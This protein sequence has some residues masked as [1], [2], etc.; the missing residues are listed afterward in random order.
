MAQSK[1]GT[2]LLDR[3]RGHAARVAMPSTDRQLLRRFARRG[4]ESAF[5]N[6]MERHGPLVLNV[7]RRVLRDVHEADDVFQATFLLLARKAGWKGWHES[8]ANW[9]YEA[10]YRLAVKARAAAHCRRLKEGRAAER[11]Q[12]GAMAI[13]ALEELRQALDEELAHLPGRWRAPLV[14]CYLQG[15]TRDEAAQELGWT[16]GMVKSRLERG[17]QL[18]HHRLSRRGLGLSAVLSAVFLAPGAASAVVPRALAE[19]TVEAAAHS[20]KGSPVRVGASA[21]RTSMAVA[22]LGVVLLLLG[23]HFLQPPGGGPTPPPARVVP[24]SPLRSVGEALSE[25]VRAER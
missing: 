16:L 14:L 21:W 12:Q 5:A 17:R 25:H 8:V 18:L 22:V 13:M 7:C 23:V 15:K 3:Q 19:A 6:L 24:A 2:V 1:S 10:A 20:A 4:D 9:L 11:R